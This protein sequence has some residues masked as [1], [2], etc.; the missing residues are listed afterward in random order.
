MY[1]DGNGIVFSQLENLKLYIC[2][3]NWSKL[4]VHLLND[5]PN[6]QILTLEVDNVSVSL[7][8][9]LR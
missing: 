8:T 5:S 1:R 2:D 3:E 7:S 6:L 9:T 4:L